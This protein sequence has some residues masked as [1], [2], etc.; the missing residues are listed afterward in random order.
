MPRIPP[1]SNAN[2][3]GSGTIWISPDQELE[4]P[5][6]TL[7]QPEPLPGTVMEF[8]PMIEYPG[9]A[10]NVIMKSTRP[11][12][13]NSASVTSSQRFRMPQKAGTPPDWSTSALNP[14][15]LPD[16]KSV[17]VKIVVLF[18]SGPLVGAV[19][20]ITLPPVVPKF[21]ENAP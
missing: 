16:V 15:D 20:A 6:P 7:V 5:G 17:K 10:A 21:V 19:A 14:K 3:P 18:P 11:P 12:A 9:A 8:G 4:T 2:E 13:P 1:P